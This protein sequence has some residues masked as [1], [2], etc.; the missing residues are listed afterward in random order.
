MRGDAWTIPLR[1][2]MRFTAPRM[3][4]EAV[5][6]AGAAGVPAT[7]E[8][9][10]PAAPSQP[11]DRF[12]TTVLSPP[13][14]V[15]EKAALDRLETAYHEA[16]HAVV[17]MY[18]GWDTDH[19]EISIGGGGFYR[20]GYTGLPIET[21]VN[22]D[23][24]VT[25]AGRLGE[26]LIVGDR[27]DASDHWLRQVIE[28]LR[29]G[30]EEHHDDFIVMSHL[31]SGDV[32]AADEILIDQFR[33]FEEETEELLLR[34]DIRAKIVALAEAL[35]RRKDGQMGDEAMATV[36][37]AEDADRPSDGAMRRRDSAEAEAMALLIG[38]DDS[39]TDHRRPAVDEDAPM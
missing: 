17:G 29:A 31:M 36:D 9:L 37:E 38:L 30:E 23:I 19:I 22:E 25:L 13:M 34:P 5:F 11:V 28:K 27:R 32:N 6:G 1:S 14:L 35:A 16:A 10:S 26:T 8:R 12:L 20:P 24:I 39:T 3:D 4:E 7:G 2:G 18:F 21:Q 33:A 15:D